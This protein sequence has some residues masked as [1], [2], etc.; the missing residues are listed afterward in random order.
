MTKMIT[1]EC[2][3]CQAHFE[4]SLTKYKQAFKIN[5]DPVFYCSRTCFHSKRRT[6]N[7]PKPKTSVTCT[8]CNTPYLKYVSK[9]R[10]CGD[11]HFCNF[12]CMAAYRTGVKFPEKQEELTCE[13]C[14]NLFI[15]SKA[16]I[17]RLAALPNYNNHYCSRECAR[18]SNK[19][20]FGRFPQQ[21]RIIKRRKRSLLELFIETQIKEEFPD[22]PLICCGKYKLFE[23][24]FYF[25]SL[26]LAIEINGPTH[27]SP[28]YG[29]QLLAKVQKRDLLKSE[30]CKTRNIKLEIIPAMNDTRPITKRNTYWNQIREIILSRISEN[31]QIELSDGFKKSETKVTDLDLKKFLPV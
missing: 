19:T 14:N 29:N 5:P 13:F 7:S 9:L 24:D 27:Y 4:K 12:T 28:I 8:Y 21:K 17:A 31:I 26:L 2:Y 1:V 6:Y 25:P 10:V 15:R 23:L 20:K 11:I 3:S 16:K 30:L 22:L 18:K